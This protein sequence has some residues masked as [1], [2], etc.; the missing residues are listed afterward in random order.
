MTPTIIDWLRGVIAAQPPGN[1]IIAFNIGR[2]E[3][4]DYFCVYLSGAR[5][6][7][8]TSD[9]WA[10]RPDYYPTN[11]FLGLHE[12][13]SG[14]TWES[15]LSEVMDAVSEALTTGLLEGTLLAKAGAVTVG[16]DDGDLH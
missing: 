16:F 1:P 2:S 11:A 9:E 3:T 4:E 14:Y 12:Q 15:C 10:I 7:V 5:A 6:Y 13:G 8:E